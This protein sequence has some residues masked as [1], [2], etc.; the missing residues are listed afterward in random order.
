MGALDRE[1][2][3]SSFQPKRKSFAGEHG[4]AIVVDV[5]TTGLDSSRHEVLEL[6]MILFAFERMSGQILRVQD[7]Y[8]GLQMPSK[9]IPAEAVAIHGICY[10][11]VK[12]QYLDSHRIRQLLNQAEF[13]VAHNARFDYSFLSLLYPETSSMIWLCSMAQIDWRSYGF[14][15][16]GLQSLLRMHGLTVKG[17]HRAYHDCQGVLLLL[18]S[19]SHRGELYFK[20]LLER[21]PQQK[22][23]SQGGSI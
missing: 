6:A 4:T 13:I 16:R 7:E 15:S 5:E 3:E 8:V 19:E 23:R 1:S 14:P 11:L 18:N 12:G 10:D 21:L 20:K 17:S 9:E 2:L 22:K